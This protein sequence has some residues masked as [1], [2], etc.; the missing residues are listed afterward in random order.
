MRCCTHRMALRLKGVFHILSPY[1]APR[2]FDYLLAFFVD[3]VIDSGLHPIKVTGPMS[4]SR[5]LSRPGNMSAG[6]IVVPLYRPDLMKQWVESVGLSE[7]HQQFELRVEQFRAACSVLATYL[8][9]YMFSRNTGCRLL[10]RQG[11]LSLTSSA[12]ITL[13]CIGKGCEASVTLCLVS[14]T[15]F[16]DTALFRLPSL[17]GFLCSKIPRIFYILLDP[18]DR[19]CSASFSIL[20]SASVLVGTIRAFAFFSS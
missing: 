14:A 17:A 13:G 4:T 3:F 1:F 2:R 6:C 20:I 18:A 10:T 8:H 12:L 16:S 5:N 19:P 7:V 9:Q 11:R 15:F